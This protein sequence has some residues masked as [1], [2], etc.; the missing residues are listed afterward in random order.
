MKTTIITL[1]LLLM[2]L[3]RAEAEGHMTFSQITIENGLSSNIVQ[4]I[5]QDTEGLMWF[6]TNDGL[7]MY[8]TYKVTTWRNNPNDPHSIGNNSIYCIFEDG[9][10]R[11]WIGTERGLYTY[12]KSSAAFHHICPDSEIGSIHVRSV[13]QDAAGNIWISSLGD[14]VYRLN[15][16]NEDI[17]NWRKDPENRSGLT[18]DYSPKVLV[19]AMGTVWCLTSGSHLYCF[20]REE[21][22]FRPII[23]RDNKT[24]IT[25][26][27]AF[28]MCLDWEGN[29]WIGGWN[30]GIFH[31][32][33]EDG[34][35]TNHLTI[36]GEPVLKGRIHTIVESEPGRLLLG[37]DQGLTEYNYNTGKLMTYSY[38]LPEHGGLSD[39]FVHDIFLDK[40]NGL[41]I[42][43][44]FGGVNYMNPNSYNFA[45]KKCAQR[46]QRGRVISKFHENN[47]GKIWIGTDD[48][49]LF[50]YDSRTG[51]SKSVVLDRSNPNLNIHALLE[52]D[53][54]LW[55][56][57]YSNGVYRM[58][59]HSGQIDHYPKFSDSETTNQSVYS[60]YKDPTGRLWLGSKTAI[61]AWTEEKGFTCMKHL[62]YHSDIISIK[63]DS[64]GDIWFA[65]ISNGLL[66]YDPKTQELNTVESTA[67]PSIPDE[68]L[69]MDTHTNQ[70]YLGTAGRGVIKYDIGTGKTSSLQ[71]NSYNMLN[72]SI[73]NIIP[74]EN[75]IWLS[76]NEGLIRYN[77]SSEKAM[78]FGKSDGLRTD[79]FNNNSGIKTSDGL[80]YLGTNDGFN[81][82]DPESI[83]IN[84]T[85][86]GTT[87]T[88][89]SFPNLR[90]G[91]HIV[92]HKGHDPFT[93]GFS[94][95]SFRSPQRNRYRYIMEGAETAW[96]ET[97]WENN[98]VRF[99]NLKCGTYTFRVC[100]CNNDGIWGDPIS[101]TFTVKAYWWNSRIAIIIY[102]IIGILLLSGIVTTFITYTF[103]KKKARAQKIKHVK[104][105]TRIETELQFF[106]NLA[107]EIRTPVML[108]TAPA[109]EIA[110]IKGLPKKVQ[111]NISLI[112][113]SSD[114]LS[115][116]TN[117]ILNFRKCN[118][119]ME[120][121]T[122]PIIQVT[123]QIV[124][125]FIPLTT[126]EGITLKFSDSTDG[127]AL[128]EIDA[129]AWNKIINNLITNAIKFTKD[130]IEVRSEI[131]EGV[132]HI[133][134]YDNGTGIA[135]DE[136]KKI[137]Q[138]FWH[139]DKAA[140]RPTPGFGLGLSITSMLAH[141]MGMKLRVASE[142][143]KYTE[144]TISVPL[145]ES[146]ATEEDIQEYLAQ[147]KEK[148]NGHEE[149][150]QIIPADDA[151]MPK[152][153]NS[154]TLLLVDD[155]EDL[156]LYLASTLS[157][158]YRILTASDGDEALQM[159]KSG[160]M[161][162]LIISDIMMPKMNGTELCE[163]LRK[164][165]N[166]SHIPIILLSS[167]SDI[168]TMMLGAETG[169]DL[170]I[171]KPVDVTYLKSQIR[172]LLERRRA[173]W[174]SF[175]KRPFL[176]LHTLAD[177][178][179]DEDLIKMFSDIVLKNLSN[180][181]LSVN[182]IADQLHMSRS[183]LF[184]KIKDLTGMTPNNLI[185]TMR[186]RKAAE[187]LIQGQQKIY[188]IC[189]EVGFNTPSYFSKC[190]YQY[191]GMNPNEF[192]ARTLRTS[193]DESEHD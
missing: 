32:N 82:F 88:Q 42:A 66:R 31:Y 146:V 99:S 147:E 5:Y 167:N 58:D 89:C 40:E 105:K 130:L 8:D 11:M 27:N 45:L 126:A 35:F 129:G 76:T 186:L 15:P 117:E 21:E 113:K 65:S 48:G 111:D 30:C 185:K 67:G 93:I 63:G 164:D 3:I 23:I 34:T 190:F 97:S 171:D 153:K 151:N 71:N 24:G 77:L 10:K 137:F 162:D 189:W 144:F 178:E 124:D 108:I 74:D 110:N 85:A 50:I 191:F 70:I 114:K 136:L 133:S 7:S 157:D 28:C 107:H 39:D 138:A 20:D 53:K 22:V 135:P 161:A 52:D 13:T 55:V 104:E 170:Y 73:L 62:G 16:E 142:L 59:I 6:G 163:S 121:A 158:K 152:G 60:L 140:K 141:R 44:Y 125:E 182:D 68:I 122:M 56:G 106:T 169:A 159:L 47:E 94:A 98:T 72:M 83:Q 183:I 134:V 29:L 184:K 149:E 177:N 25:E 78:M 102:I 80:I 61:W 57:T 100:S 41:W 118:S 193:K 127:T 36:Q 90:N 103:Q 75:D 150:G 87:F 43:T 172:N 96:Q 128:A 168:E 179:N 112:K 174:D 9:K 115:S 95:L 175:S 1:I 109:N 116:L 4:S 143:D 123:K 188:E 81:V 145:S 33:K 173:L 37:S 187:L 69:S 180:Q 119:N 166:L 91:D 192:V 12:D 181:D 86:P 38:G 155:D 156:I 49:G 18:S 19:D 54:Y 120:T 79:I 26:R 2:S 165:I 176:A 148:Q 46:N 131:R 84:Y 154:L 132:L 17:T 14:G 92:I 51:T 160:Q 64:K 139:Y 101:A